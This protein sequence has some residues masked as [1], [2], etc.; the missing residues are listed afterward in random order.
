MGKASVSYCLAPGT[1]GGWSQCCR[2]RDPFQGLRGGS[3]LALRDTQADKARD[4]IGKGRLGE[5][6]QDEGNQEDCSATW[7]SVS[8]FMMMGLVSG[9]SLANP[10]DSEPFLVV[11][12]LLSQDGCQRGG[13][14]EVVGHVVS[15]FDLSWNLP[16]GGLLVPCSLPVIK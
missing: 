8:G 11:H 1:K 13:F 7:L 3:C 2:K 4:F 9:L 10:S 5:E 14:W 12:T 6:Q 16:G 15:P